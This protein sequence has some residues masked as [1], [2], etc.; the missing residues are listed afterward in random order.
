MFEQTFD[1]IHID[2]RNNVLHFTRIG[3]G[4]DRV[5]RLAANAVDAGG[6]LALRKNPQIVKWG[7]YDAD[8]IT[9]SPN[10]KSR[11]VPLVSYHNDVATIEP[12]G[13]LTAKKPGEAMVLAM[14][15][16]LDKEIF[17]VVVM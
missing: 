5:I 16:R 1:A 9:Y 10:P 7:C 12:D 3:G 4:G 17:P 13:T 6:S 15:A 14:D 8:R 2:R 11:Y